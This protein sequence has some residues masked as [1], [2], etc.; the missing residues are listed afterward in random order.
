MIDKIKELSHIAF[1]YA[2]DN[3]DLYSSEKNELYTEKFAELIIKECIEIVQL[4]DSNISTFSGCDV[5][6]TV[7]NLKYNTVNSIKNRFGVE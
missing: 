5:F 1:D 3:Y 7:A 6:E 4:E 2:L